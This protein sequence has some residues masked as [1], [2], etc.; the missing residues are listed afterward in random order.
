MSD[1][2]QNISNIAPM[3]ED[4]KNNEDIDSVQAEYIEG[5]SLLEK[6]ELGL[7]AVALHNAL[8]GYEE[9]NNENGIANASNQLG[10]VCLAKKEYDKALQH[11]SRAEEI[12]SRLD[13]PM[14]MLALS[15]QLLL[16]YSGLGQYKKALAKGFDLL[17]YFQA[18]NNPKGT[19]ELLEQ[20]ADIFLKSDNISGA[21]DAYRTIASIHKNF[22]HD[23][24]AAGF[25]ARAVKLE[26]SI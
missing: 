18:N 9:Q 8:L 1:P 22:K 13:D 5:K 4:K 15:K 20:M 25:L 3:V 21:A 12:C 26:E 16:V 2:I 19:V 6:N 24:I 11:Y 14:S 10:H 7:A 23:K 17:D